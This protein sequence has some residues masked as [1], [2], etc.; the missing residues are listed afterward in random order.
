[1]ATSKAPSRRT[2]RR[3]IRPPVA[4][5]PTRK[6]WQ[7]TNQRTVQTNRQIWASAGRA[8]RTVT[9]SSR[10]RG[11]IFGL[12]SLGILA[13]ALSLTA[14]GTVSNLVAFEL[15]L[16]GQG[17]LIVGT[18][19]FSKDKH[20]QPSPFNQAKAKVGNAVLCGSTATKDGKPC[21]NP[22][23]CQH[24]GG[25]AA[26]ARVTTLQPQSRSPRR[27][28]HKPSRSARTGNP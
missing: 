9:H 25:K 16:A 13:G 7:L 4:Q 27:R 5:S 6:R 12:L 23:R 28:S 18:K 14:A 26:R 19:L 11:V 15:A 24:H 17:A 8:Q 3:Q 20:G 22:G 1:M 21:R 2:S 10:K